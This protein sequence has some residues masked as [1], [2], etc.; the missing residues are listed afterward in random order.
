M[1]GFWLNMIGFLLI[2]SQNIAFISISVIGVCN[3]LLKKKIV[4]N[5]AFKHSKRG[6]GQARTGILL[7]AF[8]C[9]YNCNQNG[10]ELEKNIFFSYKIKQIC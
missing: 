8:T 10:I 1:D 5:T 2:T 9:F 4:R 7:V 3:Q 6:G